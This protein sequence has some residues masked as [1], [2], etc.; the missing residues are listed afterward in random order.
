M[1]NVY[2]GKPDAWQSD[3]QWAYR[4]WAALINGTP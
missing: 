4:V 3:A 1:A 2:D